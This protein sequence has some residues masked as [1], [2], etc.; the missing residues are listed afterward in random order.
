MKENHL[1]FIAIFFTI[2]VTIFVLSLNY[3][4][5]L[6]NSFHEEIKKSIY[7]KL[8]NISKNYL[9]GNF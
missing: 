5:I 4:G 1:L 2:F 9:E 6:K 8:Q 7:Q 3:F